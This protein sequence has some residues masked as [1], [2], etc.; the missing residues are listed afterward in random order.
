MDICYPNELD[1][2][3]SY[4]PTNK[5]LYI[6]GGF[7]R[8]CILSAKSLGDIDLTSAITPSELSSLLEHST[9]KIFPASARL[10]TMIIKGQNSYEYTTFRL[11]SYPVKSGE[12]QPLSVQF[13]T[14]ITLDAMRR[15][16]KCNALYYEISSHKIVDPL[17]GIAD[18]HSKSLSTCLDPSITLSQD[19]LRIMRLFRF[20]A[21]LN[22]SIN[23]DTYFGACTQ[24][25]KLAD[26]SPE[27]ISQEL[28][29]IL[30]CDNCFDSLLQMKTSGVLNAI[31]PE[32]FQNCNAQKNSQTSLDDIFAHIFLMTQYC[33]K[34][35]RLVGLLHNLDMLE[36]L[37]PTTSAVDLI[38]PIDNNRAKANSKIV[39]AVLTRLKYPTKKIQFLTR[40]VA[41][42]FFDLTND[43]DLRATTLFVAENFDIIDD[44]ISL[45]IA[46]SR[47][48]SCACKN[49]NAQLL[50]SIQQHIIKNHLPTSFSELN[51]N[52]N[53]L[54]KIGFHDKQIGHILSQI[55]QL[56]LFE[57][58][59]NSHSALADWC[60][61]QKKLSHNSF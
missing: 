33:P 42:H 51:I 18:I 4:F 61:L 3:S 21:K 31:L 49:S 6:V 32:L 19:G 34:H 25:D 40:L 14:D 38:L 57:A 55:L 10:G 2:L 17:G 29:K 58:L 26:I 35:I 27:R 36:Y 20:V 24:I 54:M 23:T 9:F 16:F 22:F 60:I 7:V 11:D 28:D 59:P 1:L 53:D 44:I 13:C 5:P 50:R 41:T 52:G 39:A 43:T 48:S 12:H 15:D 45:K 8:D 46:G 37:S 56:C 47:A 30:D